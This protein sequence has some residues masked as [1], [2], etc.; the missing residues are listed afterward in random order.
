MSSFLVY[1]DKRFPCRR[2]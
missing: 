2:N 1:V